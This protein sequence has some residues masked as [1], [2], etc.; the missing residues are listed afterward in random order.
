[1]ERTIDEARGVRWRD[2]EML[3]QR[4]KRG[5]KKGEKL[6]TQNNEE[7]YNRPEIKPIKSWN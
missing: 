3:R 7:L 1:M 6:E 4:E 2:K 5:D